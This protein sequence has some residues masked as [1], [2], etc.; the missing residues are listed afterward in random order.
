[1][2]VQSQA[3]D[4]DRHALISRLLLLVCTTAII[5]LNA[6]TLG[7]T[8]QGEIAW[9]QLGILLITGISGFLA[10]GTVVFL[11][12]EMHV[13]NALIP[14]HL[15]LIASAVAGTGIGTA[16]HL[17]PATHFVF[18]AATGW[19]QGAI[20]FH[21][22]LLLAEQK[23]KSHNALQ[24]LQSGVLLIILCALFSTKEWPQVSDFLNALAAS[25]GV[26]FIVS[27]IL[28]RRQVQRPL[29]LERLSPS[30]VARR[31][32]TF[33]RAAQSGAL[34]QMLTNRANLSLL[35]Q[36]PAGIEASGVY[37]I[38]FYGLEA[39]WLIPRAL[40]PLVY[41]RTASENQRNFR[42]SNT[43]TQLHR[44]LLGAAV[45]LLCAVLIPESIY[46]WVFGF[47]GIRPV[48]IGL[49]PAAIAGAFSS[50][51]AHHLSGIGQHRWNAWTSAAGFITLLILATAF[52]PMLG[53]VG[54]A[55][56]AS[57][58]AI[59]QA[60]GLLA[61]WSKCESTSALKLLF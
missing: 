24:V 8:G 10:G 58:A 23:I 57:G 44:A 54:A 16:M 37:S 61:A 41:T 25:L 60:F 4:E 59:V 31:L 1:M 6:R 11:Q 19:M 33:G 32:W 2:T 21:G 40:A 55:Y 29:K 52:I 9:I 39:M 51:V 50:I 35:A 26:A 18:I 49:A 56:A 12:K 27:V 20:I 42:V 34:L 38:A 45:S 53:A 14:G 13:W 28:V 15:W 47:D 5:L 7:A 3:R 43:R 46:Q 48:V 36:A 30:H 22:Q 17:L